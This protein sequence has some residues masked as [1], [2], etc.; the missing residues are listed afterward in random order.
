M[1]IKGTSYHSPSQ[2]LSFFI[3]NGPDQFSSKSEIGESISWPRSMQK[4]VGGGGAGAPAPPRSAGPLPEGWG[5]AP[6]P[7][8]PKPRGGGRPRAGDVRISTSTRRGIHYEF[9]FRAVV[10]V[11]SPCQRREISA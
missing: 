9:V 3:G 5:G 4:W 6:P 11:G 10:D 7:P 2:N 8:T 1:F